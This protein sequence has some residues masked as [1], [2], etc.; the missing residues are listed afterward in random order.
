MDELCVHDSDSRPKPSRKKWPELSLW[1]CCA[2][3][4]IL[5]IKLFYSS[6]LCRLKLNVNVSYCWST[7]SHSHPKEKVQNFLHQLRH[8]WSNTARAFFS[9]FAF[10]AL[11]RAHYCHCIAVCVNTQLSSEKKSMNEKLFSPTPSS[12]SLS[13]SLPL[14][15][16]CI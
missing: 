9:H 13:S 1:K 4:R 5:S 16:D 7:H 8:S 14:T 15:L 6:S 11:N 10:P 3:H 12:S 2:M